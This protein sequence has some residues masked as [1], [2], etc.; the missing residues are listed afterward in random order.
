MPTGAFAI[1]P[2]Q[3]TVNITDDDV[4]AVT[5]SFAAATYTAP[6]GGSVQVKV[7]LSEAPERQ[8]TVPITKTNQGGTSNSDYSEVPGSLTF[9]ATDT[10]KTITFTATDDSAS[11]DGESVKLGFGTL[12]ARV[13]AGT[14]AEATV[15][16]TGSDVP[17]V[18]V[19]FDESSYTVA[20]GSTVTVKVKLSADPERS[21]TIPLS[22]TNQEDASS[23][24]YSGV[25]TNVTF[26][27]GDTEKTFT[28]SAASDSI[29]DDD[30]SVKIAFGT[31]P[32]GVN[33]GTKDDTTVS[34][35]DDDFPANVSVTFEK[36]SDTA[37][38]GGSV[39]VKL[40][41]SQEPE[42]A[43]SVPLTKT[44]QGGA[45]TSDYSGVPGSVSFAEDA[46]EKTFTFQATQDSVDDDGESVK[47]ELGTLPTGI[48]K[49]TNDNTVISIT[50]DDPNVSVTFEHATYNVNE[51]SSINIT[52]KLDADPERTARIPL[53]VMNQNGATD[54]D[55]SLIPEA[56][57]FNS[58]QLSRI[59]SFQADQDTD[60]DG[61]SV[62]IGFGTMPA[63]ASA[64]STSQTI[65]SITDDDVPAVNVSFEQATYTVAEGSTV[66]VKV[67][68][69]ADPERSVTIPIT[70]A[71]QGGTSSGDYS[72][73]PANL[74][75]AS[76]ETEKTISFA[77]AA[78]NDNDDGERVKLGFGTLPTLVSAGTTTETTISITDDDLPSGRLITLVVSPK[79]IDGFVPDITD[80]MVGVGADVTQATI[81]ATGYRSDDTIT[82]NGTEVTNDRAHAVDLSVGLNTYEVVVSSSGSDDETTYTV[83]IGRGTT[84]QGGWKA[85]DDLDTLRAAGNT[86]PTGVWSN[87]TTL[88]I[89]DSTD[90]KIYAYT[91]ADGARDSSKDITLHE[92]NSGPV[93]IWSNGTTL[94]VVDWNQD[95]LY[96]YT[97]ADDTRDSDKDITLNPLENTSPRGIW[98]NDTTIWV[99]DSGDAKLYAYDL[100][101]GDRVTGHDI[102][103]HFSNAGAAGIWANDDTAWAVNGI[104]TDGSPFDRMFTYNNTPVT[105]TF[106]SAA[107]TVAES[108]D[109][110]T[111]EVQ[112]N[113][114]T[115]KVKLDNDPER[116]V[117]IPITKAN[118]GGA[119]SSDYSGVPANV[120][121]AS[122]DSEKTFTF[123]AASDSAND[124]GESVKLGFG[125]LPTG[126]S[127]GSTDETTISITDDDV[128]SVTVTFEQGT[129]TV[130]EGSSV[131]VKVMISADPERS[132][133]I[134]ITKA[135]Q[136]V[137]SNSDYSGVPDNVTF[138]SG[139]TEKTIIFSATQDSV[140]DDESV[141]LASGRCLPACPQAPPTRPQSRSRTTTQPCRPRWRCRCRTSPPRMDSRRDQP[142]KLR[143]S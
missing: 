88:W 52:V 135:N 73:V 15:S 74:T 66:T 143:W 94:W 35:T 14:N 7:T 50:D 42:R 63:R 123:S 127:A 107:Y 24:D 110:S 34:I 40:T 78:D 100:T 105:V 45:S 36:A 43:I 101:N 51:G 128:P 26:A 4:P 114:V 57:T 121:F 103:L 72:G 122:G 49:G 113:Q 22:K 109:S 29:D 119:S 79:D 5:V 87:G 95:K 129:Y 98:S 139:D 19:S 125:T 83:Y 32:T 82:I 138:G 118:Q 106:E 80:Y 124:D 13:S 61:E 41:L 59:F 9:G 112:E 133:T 132:V 64:G 84:D 131:T 75:F 89:A 10:E 23:A 97:L 111:T 85:A 39:V 11:D 18:T 92:D 102:S 53:T 130:A 108:D 136:G 20:E 116:S 65:V 44:N 38:E 90:A 99:A 81:A 37:P 25:P 96:A 126:V 60:D 104:T 68:L 46:T 134:P 2:T 70:K 86:A 17:A 48:S 3:A 6:E 30:E 141:K 137:A 93:G 55:H 91:L 69:S 76:G 71:H 33:P 21:V 1:N 54:A 62:K 27:S 28:L 67:K 77:S 142:L 115:V 120:T 12:P 47:V 8:V 58:G 16:I 31:L 56:E 140:D 117:T